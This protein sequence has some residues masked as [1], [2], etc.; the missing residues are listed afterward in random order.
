MNTS[1]ADDRLTEIARLERDLQICR[2]ERDA[3]FDALLR[4]EEQRLKL[5][6]ARSRD[7]GKSEARPR[8]ARWRP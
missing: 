7:G 6:V 8:R 1:P 4:V 5:A 3:L 2:F